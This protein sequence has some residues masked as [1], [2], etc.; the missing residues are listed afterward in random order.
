MN[1][2]YNLQGG[3]VLA[4]STE[5]VWKSELFEENTAVISSKSDM[6]SLKHQHHLKIKVI[7]K[8]FWF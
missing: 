3:G 8:Y 4:S 7:G 6:I 1:L 5:L 2:L